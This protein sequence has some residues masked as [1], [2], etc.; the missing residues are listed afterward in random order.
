[1]PR[2]DSDIDAATWPRLRLA[3]FNAALFRGA[4]GELA[5]EMHAAATDQI[6]AC[7]RIIGRIAPD[8]LLLNEFDYDPAGLALRRFRNLIRRLAPALPAYP[9]LFATPC[10]TG[11]PTGLDLN[12]DGRAAGAEDAFGFGAFPGQ[13]GMALLSRYPLDRLRVRTF[14][15]YRWGRVPGMTWPVDPDTGAA[16]YDDIARRA[17]RLSSKNHWDVPV[18]VRGRRIHLLASHP[19]PPAFDGPERRNHHRNRDELRFWR[20]YLDGDAGIVDDQGGCGGAGEAPV[21]LMGDLNADPDAGNGDRES[22]SALL[23]HPRLQDP[24]PVRRSLAVAD[25]V[26]RDPATSRQTAAFG[27]LRMRLDYLL[28]DRRLAV[29]DHGVFWPRPGEAGFEDVGDGVAIVSSDHRLVWVDIDPTSA[30]TRE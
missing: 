5:R 8:I 9:Y 28:P 30:F 18:R 12:R 2:P 1:M 29:L 3:T 21:V 24:R 10:N 13:Y 19:T 11:E 6:L 16:W 15:H 17:L 14:R 23:E 20:Y 7:A 4:A 25:G 27:D 26:D 22:I